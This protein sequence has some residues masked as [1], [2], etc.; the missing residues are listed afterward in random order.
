MWSFTVCAL[1]L[2]SPV[3]LGPAEAKG[4][5]NVTGSWQNGLG[6]VLQLS[7]DGRSIHGCLTTAVEVSKGAA[8]RDMEG[9]V[10]GIRS[11]GAEPTLAFS[12]LWSGGAVTAWAGQ[13]FCK[14]ETPVLRT[15]W[16]LRSPVIAEGSWKATRIGE[17]VF[18]PV[19]KSWIC[20]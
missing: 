16:L 6:S 19:T 9:K 5:C 3:A 1:L 10:T 15:V 8:G 12:V 2:C 17:D 14:L 7:E 13:C 20:D 11:S 4:T 18:H